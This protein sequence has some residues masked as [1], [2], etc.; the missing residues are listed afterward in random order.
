MHG[1]KNK[2]RHGWIL[3]AV[4]GFSVAM[5]LTLVLIAIL[6]VLVLRGIVGEG[7]G[8][9]IIY[10]IQLIAVVIGAEL[11][12]RVSGIYNVRGPLVVTGMYTGFCF[13]GGMLLDGR[14][15]SLWIHILIIGIGFMVS[16]ALC[17][18]KIHRTGKR[19]KGVW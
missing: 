10:G 8:E 9:T 12:K 5:V 1:K 17:I 18:H 13:V 4:I 6:G 15:Q 19:K 14:F 16:C 11:S 2:R 7:N 3:S